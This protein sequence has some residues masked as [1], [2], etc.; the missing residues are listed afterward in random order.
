MSEE[1]ASL[2]AP[3][4]NYSAGI[5]PLTYLGMLLGVDPK[6]RKF[7]DPMD[8][9][10]ERKLSNWKNIMISRGGRLTLL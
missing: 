6:R 1:E 10:I 9:K 5:W 8:E 7:W 4:R 3:L 2:C